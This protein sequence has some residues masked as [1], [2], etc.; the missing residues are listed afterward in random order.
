MRSLIGATCVIAFLAGL[1]M[2]TS[3]WAEALAVG[4]VLVSMGG[5]RWK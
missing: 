3:P 1:M 4:I 5:K 2:S